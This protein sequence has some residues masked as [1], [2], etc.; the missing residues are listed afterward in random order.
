M[1]PSTTAI[2]KL[3]SHFSDITSRHSTTSMTPS[4]S[5]AASPIFA[6]CSWQPSQQAKSKKPLSVSSSQIASYVFNFIVIEYRTILT[7]V[8]VLYLTVAAFSVAALHMA[9]K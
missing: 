9:L 2:S 5:S 8:D 3:L 6:T 7:A 1:L 4:I